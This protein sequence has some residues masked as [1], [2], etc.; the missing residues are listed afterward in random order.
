MTV[1]TAAMTARGIVAV[2][3]TTN[4]V[5]KEALTIVVRTKSKTERTR[6]ECRISQEIL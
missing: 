1:S 5:A 3:T 6:H 2:V 4:V